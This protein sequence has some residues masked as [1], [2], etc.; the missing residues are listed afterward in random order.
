MIEVDARHKSFSKFRFQYFGTPKSDGF[1]VRRSKQPAENGKESSGVPSTLNRLHI[2]TI[3]PYGYNG[4]SIRNFH[5]R[6]SVCNQRCNQNVIKIDY[7]IDYS[8]AIPGT[9]FRHRKCGWFSLVHGHTLTLCYVALVNIVGH[10]LRAALNPRI[11][12]IML[13]CLSVCQKC[14]IEKFRKNFKEHWYHVQNR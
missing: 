13:R 11:R 14:G 4:E 1:S 3:S 8:H 12:S 10:H 7:I 5:I 9:E 6:L 2:D